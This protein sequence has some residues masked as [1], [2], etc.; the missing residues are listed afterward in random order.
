VVVKGDKREVESLV[1]RSEYTAS[2]MA[3]PINK[4]GELRNRNEY[5][6]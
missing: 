6:G 3:A 2:E 4:K 1:N 5:T